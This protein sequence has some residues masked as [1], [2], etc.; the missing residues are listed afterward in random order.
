MKATWF[1][2]VPATLLAAGWLALTPAGA[3]E[4]GDIKAEVE[5]LREVLR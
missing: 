4:L 2:L 5:Q 1:R 3:A